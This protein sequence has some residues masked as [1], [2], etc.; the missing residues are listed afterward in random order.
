[1][2]LEDKMR[3]LILVTALLFI[4][5]I[6]GVSKEPDWIFKVPIKL[7]NMC[8]NLKTFKVFC[9][10]YSH[11]SCQS[12]YEIG[13]GW[14]WIKVINGNFNETLTVDTYRIKGKDPSL[15]VYYKCWI[16]ARIINEGF[17]SLDEIRQKIPNCVYKPGT[18]FI[19]QY[20]GPIN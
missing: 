17:Y 13:G 18:L 5:S 4:V 2:I 8:K 7:T 3:K 11:S 15:G 14:E 6:S 16:K 10:V 9:Y 1:M 20:K 19:T 12:Q